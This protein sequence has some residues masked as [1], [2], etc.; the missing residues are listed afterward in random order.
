MKKGLTCLICMV[1]F[2]VSMGFGFAGQTAGA[3]SREAAFERYRSAIKSEYDIDIKDFKNTIPGGRAD[4]KDITKYNLNELLMG[5]KVELEHTG[6]K[7]K[8][9]EISTDH[10]EEFP[11]Y[12]TRLIKMEDDAEKEFKEKASKK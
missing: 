10:L 4:G 2:A 1:F 5:I 6:N 11:D 8:A 9:L 3:E 7:M 12:Y